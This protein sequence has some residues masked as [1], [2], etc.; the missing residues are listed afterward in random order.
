MKYDALHATFAFI[1]SFVHNFWYYELH[2]TYVD[3][4]D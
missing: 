1:L 3:D 2:S 4:L